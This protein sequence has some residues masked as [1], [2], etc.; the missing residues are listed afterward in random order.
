MAPFLTWS[1][2]RRQTFE[3]YHTLPM[4]QM[5]ELHGAAG[6]GGT[7]HQPSFLLLRCTSHPDTSRLRN[8]THA[9]PI[10]RR[11]CTSAPW[12]LTKGDS[13]MSCSKSLSRNSR[14]GGARKVFR[15]H[16]DTSKELSLSWVRRNN[17]RQKRRGKCPCL[18]RAS[19]DLQLN[20]FNFH[21]SFHNPMGNNQ[22]QSNCYCHLHIRESN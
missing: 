4:V 14:T 9:T 8:I 18:Q 16:P 21:Q 5:E 12:C 11:E 13:T 20:Q 6:T 15:R 3:A 10:T 1:T 17:Q 2:C 7:R 19:K 22:N